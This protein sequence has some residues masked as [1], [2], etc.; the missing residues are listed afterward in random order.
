MNA[1][2]VLVVVPIHKPELSRQEFFSLSHSLTI[3]RNRPSC[4]IVPQSLDKRII[5]KEFPNTSFKDFSDKYFQSTD[6]YSRLLVSSLF[7]KTFASYEFLL[8]LQPDAI[9]FKDD[10]DYWC[11]QP[12]DYIGAPWYEGFEF[13]V[14]LDQFGGAFARAVRMHVGNGGLS[15]RRVSQCLCLI[16]EFPQANTAFIT[17][18]SNEDFFFCLLGSLSSHFKLPN[19]VVASRFSMEHRP[20]YFF[21]TNGGILPMGAHGWLTISPEFWG[22]H[23]PELAKSAMT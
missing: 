13:N 10:L 2:K 5:H 3:L 1:H 15:L 22:Q 12:F 18:G 4:F 23:Y 8:I 21:H 7:Y 19:Q 6:D 20:D 16:D 14:N 17:T 11:S 9:V